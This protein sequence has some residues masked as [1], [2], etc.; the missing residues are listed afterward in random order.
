MSVRA[1]HDR[2]VLA[3]LLGR[4]PALHAYELGDLDDIFWPHTSWYRRGDAVALLYHGAVSPTLLALTRPA[5]VGAV[6][7]AAG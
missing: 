4:D 7:A 1:E 6:A 3:G 5:G 2:V